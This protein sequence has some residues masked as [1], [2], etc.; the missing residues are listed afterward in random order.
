MRE[1]GEEEEDEEERRRENEA[2]GDRQTRRRQQ[3]TSL[4]R[5][6]PRKL[7]T[8]V[9]E[10]EGDGGDLVSERGKVGA[11]HSRYSRAQP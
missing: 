5:A 8:R 11:Q 3:G 6:R 7:G 1:E 2:M 4:H 9:V 10:R